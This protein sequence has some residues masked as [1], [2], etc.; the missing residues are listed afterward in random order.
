[1]AQQVH[2]MVV[3]SR[4]RANRYYRAALEASP[5]YV[6]AAALRAKLLDTQQSLPAVPAV[7]A[8]ES[9]DADMG[10]WLDA[11]TEADAAERSREVKFNALRDRLMWCDKV[12]EDAAAIETNRILSSLNDDLRDVMDQVA[13]V[14]E[15]LD[16]ARTPQEVIDAGVGDVWKVAAATRFLRQDPAGTRVGDGW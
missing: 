11:V 13:A 14:V 1:M 12:V 3:Y 7:V 10:A 8:P 15:R 16:G 4:A 6:G 2:A 9:P 5:P